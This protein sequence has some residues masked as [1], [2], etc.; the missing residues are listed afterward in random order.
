MTRHWP[1]DA[2]GG[3][4]NAALHACSD[5]LEGAES[6][7]TAEKAFRDAALE[8]QILDGRTD[9]SRQGIKSAA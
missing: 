3:K 6:V 8:A 2:K 5:V 9:A 1:E 4:F 7:E